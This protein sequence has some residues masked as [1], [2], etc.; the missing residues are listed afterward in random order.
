VQPH[1]TAN[2]RLVLPDQVGSG[3]LIA[4]ANAVNQ[5]EELVL[6]SHSSVL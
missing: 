4:G 1:F 6:V 2:E 3:L 5:V